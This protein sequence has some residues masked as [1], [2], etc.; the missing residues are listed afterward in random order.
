MYRHMTGVHN[1]CYLWTFKDWLS[2]KLWSW[3]NFTSW[4]TTLLLL[5]ILPPRYLVSS[6]SLTTLPTQSPLCRSKATQSSDL[7]WWSTLYVNL[8]RSQCPDIGSNSILD[9]SVRV[10]WMKFICQ[11][12]LWQKQ[13]ALIMWVYLTQS[14][15]G[16][17]ELN[18]M[19]ISPKQEK[20]LQRTAFRF[21]LRHQLFLVQQQIAPH[22]N[23]NSSLRF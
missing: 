20:I 12:G 23:W 19:L 11:S 18:K 21:Y 2:G 10:F 4:F 13:I 5:T 15:E 1:Y 6:M 7:M 9:V 8:A 3:K 17:P 16:R 22:S 14:A